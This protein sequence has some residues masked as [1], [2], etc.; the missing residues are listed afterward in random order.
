MQAPSSGGVRAPAQS[1]PR[2]SSVW[3]PH[4][5]ATTRPVPLPTAARARVVFRSVRH[6][7]ARVP[8]AA[9]RSQAERTRSERATTTRPTFAIAR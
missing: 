5:C 7:A 9:A 6:V 4:A 8:R 2:T 1:P 3:F